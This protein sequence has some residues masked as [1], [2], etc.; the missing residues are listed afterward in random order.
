MW[1]I[2]LNCGA[3]SHWTLGVPPLHAGFGPYFFPHA[4]AQA[5]VM[6]HSTRIVTLAPNN[7]GDQLQKC[8]SPVP[9]K[10]PKNG[11]CLSQTGCRGKCRKSAS[12]FEP[13]YIAR[14]MRKIC[15]EALS[16]PLS[17]LSP[18]LCENC[19]RTTF[20]QLLRKKKRGSRT[21]FAQ[22]F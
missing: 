14:T 4:S 19:A 21:I 18:K 12:A 13:L 6:Q 3:L 22:F 9:T 16:G 20:A 17:H 11:K 10:V 5:S 1:F 15:A 7:R 8:R 2:S